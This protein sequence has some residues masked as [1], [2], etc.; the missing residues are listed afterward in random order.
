MKNII[1]LTIL[2]L[3]SLRLQAQLVIEN[4]ALFNSTGA[5]VVTLQH[6]NLINNGTYVQAAGG[7]TIFA[8]TGNDTIMGTASPLSGFDTLEIAKTGAGR[9]VILQ[10]LKNN[11]G[12]KF[13]SGIIDLHGHIISLQQNAVLTGESET[14]YITDTLYGGYLITTRTLNAPVAV[15]PG[16]LGAIITSAQNM[17]VTTVRR[18]HMA[19]ANG[20]NTGNSIKR[21]YDINPANNIN[22]GAT[23]RILYRD[24]ELNG[25]TESALDLWKSTD[26]VVWVNAGSSSKNATSNYVEQTGIADFSRWTL[27]AL[28]SPLP[29]LLTR[30]GADCGQGI[31]KLDWTTA[32]EHNISHFE[33]QQSAD[34]R[35]WAGI[36]TV[37][38]KE[39]VH[40]YSYEDKE[41]KQGYYRLLVRDKDGR[42]VYSQVQYVSC[43]SAGTDIAVWPNPVADQLHLA[44]AA[45]TASDMAIRVYDAK[46]ALIH[47]ESKALRTGENKLDM[48]F[49][50]FAAGIYWL[51][52]DWNMGASRKTLK[53][54][55]Q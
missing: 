14:S 27:S 29:L 53:V 2:F 10:D 4:G 8:G 26:T 43:A 50:N 39:S 46:G 44:V 31:I 51:N 16:N 13:T 23:L 32:Q 37:A 24:A 54:V 30:F 25:I 45:V 11:G 40:N 6:T 55:K 18:G 48:D 42:H 49:Q 34:A 9:L 33:V 7:K 20:N 17:G 36:T 1:I 28:N 41:G 19:Q 21:Y 5:A 15:N 52:I 12:L 38:F 3:A 35:S 22:L 47:Q